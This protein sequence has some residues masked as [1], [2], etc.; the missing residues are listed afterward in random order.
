MLSIL[1]VWVFRS[2]W[3]H[4]A[5]GC[6]PLFP[7]KWVNKLIKV[8]TWICWGGHVSAWVWVWKALPPCAVTRHTVRVIK[9]G[10]QRFWGGRWGG[11]L[12]DRP[13]TLGAEGTAESSHCHTLK[14]TVVTHQRDGQPCS[15]PAFLGEKARVW[16]VADPGPFR[17]CSGRWWSYSLER[18]HLEMGGGAQGQRQTERLRLSV[19]RGQGSMDQCRFFTPEKSCT[20]EI[21]HNAKLEH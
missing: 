12:Y 1:C 18:G 6:D 7:D 14:K 20:V 8:G 3:I 21:I 13:G 11:G 19:G 10:L 4:S 15:P 17:F 16:E 5:A 2:T 9:L